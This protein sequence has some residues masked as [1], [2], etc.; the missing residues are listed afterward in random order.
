M[1][2]AAWTASFQISSFE[3]CQTNSLNTALHIFRRRGTVLQVHHVTTTNIATLC[4][5]HRLKRAIRL[6]TSA[7][8]SQSLSAMCGKV[9]PSIISDALKVENGA[10]YGSHHALQDVHYAQTAIGAETEGIVQDTAR[11]A[12]TYLQ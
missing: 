12:H 4:S 10:S 7:L 5:K 2:A 3:T 1:A 6:F 8:H 9:S 11:Q